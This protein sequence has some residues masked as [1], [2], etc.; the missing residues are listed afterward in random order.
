M[1]DLDRFKSIN[2]THGHDVGD[3]VLKK[4]AAILKTNTRASNICGRIGGEEFVA[5]ITHSHRAGVQIAIERVRQEVESQ[6]FAIDRATIQVTA[7]FG[8]AGFHGRQAP[9]FAQLLREA[10]VALY[11]AK[12]HGRNRI[13]FAQANTIAQASDAEPSACYENGTRKLTA[14]V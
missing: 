2:D 1:A 4:F 14:P 10:D 9:Q 12:H 8:I 3:E 6:T 7:S 11:A 5:V 13:E